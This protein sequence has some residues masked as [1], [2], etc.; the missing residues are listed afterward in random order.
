MVKVYTEQLQENKMILER[1]ENIIG[2]LPKSFSE[3]KKMF[4]N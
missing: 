1:E 4:A 2:R 3:S